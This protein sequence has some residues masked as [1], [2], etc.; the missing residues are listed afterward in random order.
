MAVRFSKGA[1]QRSAGFFDYKKSGP[2][3]GVR[4]EFVSARIFGSPQPDINYTSGNG[5]RFSRS[6]G[7][8]RKSLPKSLDAGGDY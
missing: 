1:P 5:K 6:R 8:V 7:T 2:R 3:Q 4:K